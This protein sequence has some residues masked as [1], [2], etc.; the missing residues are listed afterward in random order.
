MSRLPPRPG[1]QIDRSRDIS[2][3]FDGKPVKALEGDTIALGAARLG[4]PHL[5]AQLQVPPPARAHVLRRAVPELPGRGRRLARRPRL[6]R[7]GPRGDEGRAPERGPRSTSTRCGPPTSSA[8]RSRRRASTTRPSSARAGCGRSTRGCCATPPAWARLPKPR[9]EREW[10]TEYRRR[11]ADVLVIGGGPRRPRRRAARRGARRRRRAGRRGP[12]ARRRIYSPTA[13]PGAPARSPPRRA[14]PGVEVSIP[15]AA[16]GF[17][18]GLVPVW[19][20]DTLH[21]VRAA[22]HVAATGSIEQP[23]VFEGNDLPGVMLSRGVRRLLAM[24]CGPPGVAPSSRQRASAGSK[25]RWRCAE[26]G[27]AIAAVADLR[28]APGAP[29]ARPRRRAAEARRA[30]DRGPQPDHGRRGEGPQGG[31]ARCA[32]AWLDG[33]GEPQGSEESVDCDLLAVSG[34]TC[35]GHLPAAAGGR[36]GTAYDPARAAFGVVEVPEGVHAA[37]D[38]RRVHGSPRRSRRRARSPAPRR[39]SRRASAMPRRA[40]RTRPGGAS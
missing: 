35:P 26:A 19:E 3:E 24:Y 10:R 22:R 36:G 20:G 23:L 13:T 8:A 7:A 38:A 16:L 37:G 9:P 25:P 4:P 5:L 29:E 11:H 34:G 12:G 6:H 32:G 17:F 18:D 2:F 1:E 15:A 33:D 14:R 27:V 40:T 21:Q 30:R 39:R 28:P 31:E